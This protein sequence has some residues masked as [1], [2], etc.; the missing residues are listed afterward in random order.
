MLNSEKYE[1]N[2]YKEKAEE[3]VN[4]NI[5][6]YIGT[7]G[8]KFERDLADYLNLRYDNVTFYG[9]TYPQEVHISLG[10]LPTAEQFDDGTISIFSYT[11][12][13]YDLTQRILDTADKEEWELIENE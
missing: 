6:K 12:D 3:F 4:N 13:G 2:Q 1:F 5:S 9:N 10:N 11:V 7:I 8:G